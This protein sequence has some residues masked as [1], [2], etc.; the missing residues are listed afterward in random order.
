[1][2]EFIG[3][4][5]IT[6]LISRVFLKYVL[7]GRESVREALLAALLTLGTVLL[8]TAW[9]M[10]VEAGFIIYAPAI[11]VWLVVDTVRFA[12]KEHRAGKEP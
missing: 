10:G 4:L 9:T 2:V 3:A 5:V 7:K 11:G 6:L 1:M 12:L 8:I